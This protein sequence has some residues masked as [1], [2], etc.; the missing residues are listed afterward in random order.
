MDNAFPIGRQ[1][2][3]SALPEAENY[4]RYLYTSLRKHLGS[5]VWE[6]GSGYGQYTQMLLQDQKSVLAS[7]IDQEMLVRLATLRQS[8]SSKLE[9]KFVDLYKQETIEN[10]CR[11]KPDSILCLNVLEH[12]ETDWQCLKQINECL[13]G[14]LRAIF[15]TPA[16]AMLYGF[17]DK[18]AG[19]FRRYTRRTLSE[20]FSKADWQVKSSF[21]M[22][23]VGGLGWFVQNRL[24]PEPKGGLDAPTVNS[25]IR[26]FNQ[27]AL[28]VTKALEPLSRNFF[29]QS[30]VVIAERS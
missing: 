15:L 4:H 20:A 19:H 8:N 1:T 17:M 2:M 3:S 18:E 25:K 14:P 29:G 21:Y 23:P 26:L 11:F 24:L 16:H 28:P 9:V 27:Y 30:V 12:I 7:D 5:R 22:N 6:I 13:A 10:C